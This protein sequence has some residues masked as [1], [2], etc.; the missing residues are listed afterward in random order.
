MTGFG[1]SRPFRISAQALSALI[2]H[3]IER[4][5][6]HVFHTVPRDEALRVN[7]VTFAADTLQLQFA[8]LDLDRAYPTH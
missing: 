1:R 3:P 2:S 4:P 6:V 7:E 5:S 8:Y